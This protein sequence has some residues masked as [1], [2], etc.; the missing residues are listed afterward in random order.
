MGLEI[1]KINKR[2][3]VT[4]KANNVEFTIGAIGE[5]K[6]KVLS[7]R[8]P[9]AQ[10]HDPNACW[11]PNWAFSEACRKAAAILFH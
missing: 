4:F 9:N 3:S 7:K 8:K 6:L 1:L 2:K 5:K 11:I 10:I